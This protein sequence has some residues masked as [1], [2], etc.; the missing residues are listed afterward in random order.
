M[1][2][3]I[4]DFQLRQYPPVTKVQQIAIFQNGEFETAPRR[5]ARMLG[6]GHTKS[7]CKDA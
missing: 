6:S 7:L 4:I 5:Q 3:F 1:A 2:V